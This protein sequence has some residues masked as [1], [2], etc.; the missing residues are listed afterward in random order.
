MCTALPGARTH[1]P[2]GRGP[3]REVPVSWKERLVNSSIGVRGD[4]PVPEASTVLWEPRGGGINFVSGAGA[5]F[6]E[7]VTFELDVERR[8]LHRTES[9]PSAKRVSLEKQPS[10]PGE[11]SQPHTGFSR[12]PAWRPRP[13]SA[14]PAVLPPVRSPP[15][16]SCCPAN[17]PALRPSNTTCVSFHQE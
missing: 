4:K 14:Q 1:G 15:G 7:E 3:A 8:T 6:A 5:V 2:S 11:G 10:R 16:N 9:G 17:C 12:L 13:A